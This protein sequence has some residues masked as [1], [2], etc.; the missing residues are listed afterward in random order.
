[1]SSNEH[2]DSHIIGVTHCYLC[3]RI[4]TKKKNTFSPDAYDNATL[5]HNAEKSKIAKKSQS[6]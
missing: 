4:F 6:V 3:I 5:I 1:M 2:I